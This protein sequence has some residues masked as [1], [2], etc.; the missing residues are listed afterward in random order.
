MLR[1]NMWLVPLVKTKAEIMKKKFGL[2]Q[3]SVQWTQPNLGDQIGRCYR[4]EL[5]HED[6][7]QPT[8]AI[9]TSLQF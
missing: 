5:L 8:T 7:N 2:Y 3:L 6:S 1:H 4:M 9:H